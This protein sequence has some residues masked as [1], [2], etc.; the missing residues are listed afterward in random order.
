MVIVTLSDTSGTHEMV[1]CDLKM[2]LK[3]AERWC[4][5]F[6]RTFRINDDATLRL[7]YHGDH[8][9]VIKVEKKTSEQNRHRVI[10]SATEE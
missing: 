3:M 8:Y 2:A 1:R 10:I 5:G 4:E 6:C 9:D 7:L